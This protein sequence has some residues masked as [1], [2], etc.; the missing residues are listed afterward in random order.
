MLHF[1]DTH[2]HTL[3]FCIYALAGLQ[4]GSA[5]VVTVATYKTPLDRNINQIG[6]QPDVRVRSDSCI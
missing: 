1:N 5:L 4:D 6:I 2:S 3:C